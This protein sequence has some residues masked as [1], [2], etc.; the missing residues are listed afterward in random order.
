[1]VGMFLVLLRPSLG[2]AGVPVHLT[3]KAEMY[4]EKAQMS[5]KYSFF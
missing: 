5:I 1:M 2:V 3:M 4:L